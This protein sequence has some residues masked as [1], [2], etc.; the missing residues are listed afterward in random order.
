ML[1]HAATKVISIISV[2][3]YVQVSRRR[4]YRYRNRLCYV[5]NIFSVAEEQGRF[6]IIR[7]HANERHPGFW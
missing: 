7:R 1:K 4:L 5:I 2:L 6:T 3:N